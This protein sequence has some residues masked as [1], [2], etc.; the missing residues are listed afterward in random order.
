MTPWQT[1]AVKLLWRMERDDTWSARRWQPVPRGT[2]VVR[3]SVWALVIYVVQ[4]RKTKLAVVS[5]TRVC[6]YR[7]AAQMQFASLERCVHKQL[8]P[9][10]ALL[11]ATLAVD[12]STCIAS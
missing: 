7:C 10:R 1:G 4:S 8:A 6:C 12:V 2:K 9:L 11:I 3:V 5:F